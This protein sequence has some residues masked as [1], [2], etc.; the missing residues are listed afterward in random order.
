MP[1]CNPRALGDSQNCLIWLWK[2]TSVFQ[3][4][5]CLWS[6]PKPPHK[7]QTFIHLNHLLVCRSTYWRSTNLNL[8]FR[9]GLCPGKDQ[10]LLELAGTWWDWQK[11]HTLEQ[12]EVAVFKSTGQLDGYGTPSSLNTSL[13]SRDGK[14]STWPRCLSQHNNNCGMRSVLAT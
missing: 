11:R 3:H 8:E 6:V 10:A 5:R 4:S 14:S 12:Y 13:F 9:N 7:Q 2:R 1:S